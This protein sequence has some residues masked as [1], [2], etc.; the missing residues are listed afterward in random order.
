[1]VGIAG[2]GDPLATSHAEETFRS[3]HARFPELIMCMSTNGLLLEEK[4]EDLAEAGVRT[5]TVTINATLLKTFVGVYAGIV[6]RG[7]YLTGTDAGQVLIPAQY[8]GVEK[9]VSLGMTVKINTVL[10]PGVNEDEIGEIAYRASLSGASRI[11]IIPLI[12]QHEMAE[13]DA[14]GCDAVNKAREQAERY[15]PVFRHC[16]HCRADA[17]GIPGSGKDFAEKLYD[18]P[19]ETFSHG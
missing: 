5:I 8:A 19:M 14:P 7:N 9:A 13:C 3:I 4:A 15:L 16:R 2:P 6:Y 10:I 1:V 11:N 18:V 12:P 17:C